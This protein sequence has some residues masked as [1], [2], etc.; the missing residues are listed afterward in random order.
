MHQLFITNPTH[1]STNAISLN[2]STIEL[3][4]SR[5]PNQR[6]FSSNRPISATSILK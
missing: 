3:S 1:H 2:N 5:Y 4:R 6:F